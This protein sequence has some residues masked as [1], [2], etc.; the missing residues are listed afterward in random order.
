MPYKA[1][2]NSIRTMKQIFALGALAILVGLGVV[3][4]KKTPVIIDNSQTIKVP[5]ALFLGSKLGQIS[6]TNN[7]VDF[8][9]MQDQPGTFSHAIL[10]ADSNIVYVRSVVS[11]GNGL[12]PLNK[13]A[14]QVETS[15]NPLLLNGVKTDHSYPGIAAYDEKN[16]VSY[17]CGLTYLYENSATGIIGQWKQASFGT[18]VVGTMG[19]VTVASDG[20]VYCWDFGQ[21]LFKKVNGIGGFSQVVFGANKP[22]VSNNEKYFI[23][24]YNSDLIAT[25]R[26]GSVSFISTD[27]GVNWTKL[28]GLPVNGQEILFAKQEKLNGNFYLSVDSTGLYKLVGNTYVRETSNIPSGSRVW[29]IVGKRNIYRT[30]A[31]KDYFYLATSAGL[32]MSENGTQTWNKIRNDEYT[33]LR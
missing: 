26:N 18:T 20:D 21:K 3:G 19:S 30:D 10:L 1:I 33:A 32:L 24:S 9:T 28:N 12:V 11:V 15:F 23:S 25:D 4:C 13:F 6:K 2:K 16:K 27:D 14:A 29:D 5:Y 31:Q 22:S 8:Q 17:I 7:G